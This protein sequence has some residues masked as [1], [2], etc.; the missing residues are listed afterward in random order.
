V[1]YAKQFDAL[2]RR[3][4]VEDAAFARSMAKCEPWKAQGGKSRSNFW[5]TSDDRFIIKT[6]VNAWNV[7]DLQVLIELAPSYFMHMESTASRASIL[8]KLLGFFT[9]EVRNLEHGTVIAKADL[10]VM[11]NLFHGQKPTKTFDLKGIQGR[12]VKA[13]SNSSASKTLFDSEWIEGQQRAL[14]LVNPIS[15]AIFQEAVR[16]DCDFLARSNIMDYSLLLGVDEEGKQIHCGL[17]DTIGS[18]TFAKTLE[19]K[20]KGLSKEG[21]DITVVPPHEYQERFVSTLDSYFMACPDKWT[22][23]VDETKLIHDAAHLPS[24]L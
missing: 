10:L 14:T 16:A 11:E 12:K 24:V 9:V 5:K 23:P 13:S 6:L 18:Y 8:A 20:A 21:K 17:V 22:K 1:Y 3:C 2:R 19:Y 7:A 4:G 15:K